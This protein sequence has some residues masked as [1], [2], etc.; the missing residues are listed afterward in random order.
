MPQLIY[1][2]LND[3]GSLAAAGDFPNIID[4]GDASIERMT[5]DLKTPDGPITGS[6][7]LSIRGSDTEGG[8]Y[9]VITR[10][11]TVTADD[12]AAGYRMPVPANPY[13]FIKVDLIGSFAGT[14]QAI[15]N[16]YLGK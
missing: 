4:L 5:V 7:T 15:L 13:R 11:G 16:S 8:T 1:D 9:N 10:S 3:F 12:I 2:K 6:V 14:V